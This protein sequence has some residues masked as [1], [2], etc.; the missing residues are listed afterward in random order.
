MEFVLVARARQVHILG[1]KHK[2]SS[3]MPQVFVFCTFIKRS[4]NN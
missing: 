1:N 3:G 4:F 2:D